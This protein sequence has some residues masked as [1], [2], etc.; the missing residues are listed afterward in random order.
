MKYTE[1]EI[2]QILQQANVSELDKCMIKLILEWENE[3]DKVDLDSMLDIGKEFCINTT[4][5]GRSFLRKV[6]LGHI[7]KKKENQ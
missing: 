5:N 1:E 3:I 4:E 6:G 2:Q 7:I